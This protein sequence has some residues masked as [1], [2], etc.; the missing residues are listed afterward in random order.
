MKKATFALAL[1]VSAQ[2]FAGEPV[3]SKKVVV[4]PEEDHWKFLLAAPGWLPNVNGTVGLNGFN[5]HIDVG[6][7]TLVPKIDMVWATR[8]EVSK[9]RFGVLGELIY[10]SASDGT[11]T[12]T[13]VQKVDVRLDQYLADFTLRY[14]LLEG[15]RGYLDV[16]AGVRYTNVYQ[17]LSLRP[18]DEA[19]KRVA[20]NFTDEIGD[21]LSE[22]IK[23]TLSE[24]RFRNALKDL[25]AG[26]IGDKI[27]SV[28]GRDSAE[29]SVGNAPLG[30]RTEGRVGSLIERL[31]RRRERELV[32]NAVA[33]LRAAEEAEKA[34]LQEKAAAAREKLKAK[35]AQLRAKVDGR[36]ASTKKQIERDI[37]KALTKNLDQDVTRDDAWWDPYV[38][39]RARYN[40]NSTFY[41]IARGDIGGFGVGSELMWQAEGALGCQLSNSIY[42]E[43]G[44]RALSFDYDNNGLVYDVITHGAQL[45]MGVEF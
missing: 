19:I 45:T 38:G 29:R 18:N 32:A 37:R 41:V 23:D 11:G 33:D 1:F 26:R 9:G 28:T 13:V 4:P 24:G 8:A 3:D 27:A 12:D 30:Y 25:V 7:D 16:L 2:A 5:T 22:R 43:L 14:R 39:L 36:I 20:E 31:V 21:R 35:A 34:A 17:S 40:F 44:Y 6:A 10:L 42:A 15:P